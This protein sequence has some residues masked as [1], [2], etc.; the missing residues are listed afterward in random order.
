[1]KRIIPQEYGFDRFHQIHYHS[2][3]SMKER[4]SH[5]LINKPLQLRFMLYIIATLVTVSGV[6]IISFYFGIWGNVLDAF[7]NSQ[8]RDELLI[9]SRISEYESARLTGQDKPP[10]S[11]SFFK[12]ADRLSRRQQE[13]FKTILDNTNKQLMPKFLFLVILI[14]WGSIYLSHKIAGPLYRF[15]ISL[16]ELEKGNMGVR[17]HLRESD[18]A[19]F[20]GS[21]FN[22]TAQSLDMSFSRLKNILNENAENPERLKNRFQEELAK[23]KTSASR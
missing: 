1:M 6:V 11:L 17:I 3:H 15:E 19:Q 5:F 18:E 12:Q 7:S 22:K 9:A 23:I 21:Q 13:V 20:L 4:R 14:A 16:Q 8:L 10:A 2:S